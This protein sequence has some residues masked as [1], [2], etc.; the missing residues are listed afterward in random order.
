MY[1]LNENIIT[2]YSKWKEGYT[3]K[4][5]SFEQRVKN[6]LSNRKNADIFY[7]SAD[8]KHLDASSDVYIFHEDILDGK[9]IVP[10][11]EV[12]G[13]FDCCR[14]DSL[15]SLEGAPKKVEGGFNCSEC[16]NLLSLEGATE[17]VGKNF[18][19]SWCENLTSLKG[20]PENVGGIFYCN[21]CENLTSLEGAPKKIDNDFD[22]SGCKSL[23]SLEGAT[24]EVGRDFNCNNCENLTSLKGAPENL[25]FFDCSGCEKLSSLEY[26]PKEVE[27]LH[28]DERFEDKIP[29]DVT[30]KGKVVLNKTKI[31]KW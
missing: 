16:K 2:L 31:K 9:F 5:N 22:C 20:A 17:N 13:Y 18:D 6:F 24:D 29:M 25:R 23:T 15:T 19:C 7:I 30:I 28:I 3:R 27:H 11:G 14:Q 12:K 4:E 8:G 1:K 26:L 10:F 21:N